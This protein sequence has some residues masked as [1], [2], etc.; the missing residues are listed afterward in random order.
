MQRYSYNSLSAV[1][2]CHLCHRRFRF[3][4]LCGPL[5][6]WAILFSGCPREGESTCVMQTKRLLARYFINRFREFNQI[7]NF[8][9]VRDKYELIRFWGQKVKGEGHSEIKCTFPADDLVIVLRFISSAILTMNTVVC[10]VRFCQQRIRYVGAP[11]DRAPDDPRRPILWF[12]IIFESAAAGGN[13]EDDVG[14]AVRLLAAQVSSSRR[15]SHQSIYGCDD[16]E[17]EETMWGQA[18]ILQV[19]RYGKV[20]RSEVWNH[21]QPVRPFRDGLPHGLNEP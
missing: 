14:A 16:C 18:L 15:D 3:L 19:W 2:Q 7:C 21:W 11:V 20:R 10:N 13:S 12:I 5:A 17:E 6:T 9:T 8:G 1:N 4:C